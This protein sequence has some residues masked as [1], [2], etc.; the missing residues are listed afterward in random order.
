MLALAATQ[1]G[2]VTGDQ[3]VALGLS[4]DGIR[5]RTRRGRLFRM[6]KNIYAVGSPELTRE[7]RWTVAVLACGP[8]AALSHESAAALWGFRDR[9]RG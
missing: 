3:L 9:E 2:V 6:R 8:T 1:H 4:R 7:G 5:Y